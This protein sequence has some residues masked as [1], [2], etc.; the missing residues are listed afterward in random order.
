MSLIFV[1]LG[2]QGGIIIL[3]FTS[4]S[5]QDK[6]VEVGSA[7]L[8]LARIV[9][10][11]IMHLSL[12]PELRLCM[13]MLQYVTYKGHTFY[14]RNVFFPTVILIGKFLGA[15]MTEALTVYTLLRKDTILDVINSYIATF[16][17]AKI[18]TV[19]AST[20][21]SFDVEDEMT[22]KKIMYDKHT[23]FADDIEEIKKYYTDKK[24]NLLQ[25]V[26]MLFIIIINRAMRIFY[27]VVYFY[28]TPIFVVVLV[29]LSAIGDYKPTEIIAKISEGLNK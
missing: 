2:I 23:Y 3:M 11:I 18:G 1:T 25:W 8:N 5:L 9:S 26:G 10:A 21:L 29:Q 13:E 15:G 28:F 22:A 16:L 20:I 27:N 17:I 4:P 14:G 12:F 7:S 19:M 24:M 6:S